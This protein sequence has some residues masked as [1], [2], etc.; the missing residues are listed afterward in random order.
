MMGS[1]PKS[2]GDMVMNEYLKGLAEI[3]K[4][5]PLKIERLEE[6]DK[7][8][9]AGPWRWRNAIGGNGPELV[10]PPKGML[11]VMGAVRNG[12]Q[13]ATFTFAVR[14]GSKGGL[15]YKAT[16]LLPKPSREIGDYP[17]VTNPD[18]RMVA[19]ARNALGHLLA[20][21][22]AAKKFDVAM[23]C[24]DPHAIGIAQRGIREALAQLEAKP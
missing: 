19:E 15:L 22:K 12:M 17:V 14:E 21:A 5:H 9:T 8:A 16:E 13:R 20:V 10:S 7:A 23:A 6:L 1:E 4:E 11:Y 24:C 3:A 2:Y 18:M